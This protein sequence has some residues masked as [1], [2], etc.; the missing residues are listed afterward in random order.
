MS[1]VTRAARKGRAMIIG[2]KRRAAVSRKG[3][4]LSGKSGETCVTRRKENDARLEDH[5][6]ERERERKM[7]R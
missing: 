6:R 4:Y 1:E 5:R 2:G 7:K 3:D